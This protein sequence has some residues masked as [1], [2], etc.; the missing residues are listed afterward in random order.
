MYHNVI[1]DKVLCINS[2][3]SHIFINMVYRIVA[4][5]IWRQAS[6]V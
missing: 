2:Y 3:N 1:E 5:Q 4:E 6:S